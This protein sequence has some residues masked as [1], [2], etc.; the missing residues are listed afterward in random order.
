MTPL[1]GHGLRLAPLFKSAGLVLACLLTAPLGLA[2]ELC[3]AAYFQAMEAAPRAAALHPGA[4]VVEYSLEIGSTVASPAGETVTVLTINGSSPGPVLRFREGD[5]ARITVRNTLKDEETSIHWHGLL[6]PNLEDG[7]PLLTTPVIGP[8]QSRTFEFLVRQ[9][10]TYWYHSHTAHQEQ[11]G[12][13]G[14][15]VIE[16]REAPAPTSTR[17]EVIVL[18]DWTNENPLAVQRALHRGDDWYAI[19]KGTAQSVFGAWRAGQLGAYFDREKSLVPPMDLGDVAYDAFLMNGQRRL[20]LKAK[21][22]ETIRLRFINAGAASYFYL[23]AA[24]G[25]LSVIAADG[26]DVRPTDVKRLLI[27]PA[28]CYDV[29]VTVPTSGSWEVRATAQDGSGAVSAWLGEGAAHAADGPPAPN[30]YGMSAYLTSILDQLDPEPG[31][32][33]ATRPLA[34][35]AALRSARPHAVPANFREVTFK[36]TGDMIRYK[37]SFD[38]LTAE[39]AGPLKVKRGETIR[40]KLVNNT[41]MHH[42]IHFHGHFFRL[43]TPGENEPATAPLKHTVD[44]PPMSTRLIEFTADEGD[45]D[46]LL[47]CH[48]LYHH[49]SG[50]MRVVRVTGPDGEEPP[51]TPALHAMPAT[52]AWGE[53]TFTSA[54]HQ[55]ALTLR[56]DEH[57]LTLDWMQGSHTGDGHEGLLAYRHY[58]S[59]KWT[60]F[61]GYRWDTMTRGVDGFV[62]GVTYRLP[63][64]VD[65]TLTQQSGGETRVAVAKNLQILDRLSLQ[66]TIQNGRRTGASGTALFDYRLTKEASLSLGYSSEFGTG[67]GVTVRF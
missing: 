33:P 43:I 29:L 24:M 66:L 3:R 45:G 22:G 10:G 18:G 52:F 19:R 31:T 46:W 44:V 48:L 13:H 64:F 54:F 40:V 62:A 28:E 8:G 61:A 16:P 60:A 21:P 37:W 32:P 27:G 53:A 39:E 7:V 6:V 23:D 50:M 1:L 15:I 4:K 20:P 25:P 42:P 26:Q 56:L 14:G 34:P 35:Y 41:M 2:C 47:H 58:F 17:D 38:G 9:H 36:L 55:A 57:D 67:A 51:H 49:A 65:V 11:R 63:Y 30:P 5:V 12:I 59:P